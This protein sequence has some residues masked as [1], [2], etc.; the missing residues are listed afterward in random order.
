MSKEGLKDVGNSS[1]FP[2]GKGV[3]MKS[4]LTINMPRE[5]AF[6]DPEEVKGGRGSRF[7]HLRYFPLLFTCPLHSP[8]CL[9]P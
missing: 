7:I 8:N 3:Y 4:I 5:I 1:R 2:Y 6:Q 9:S